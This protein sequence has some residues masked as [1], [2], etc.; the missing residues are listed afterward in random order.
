MNEEPRNP[1]LLEASF[2]TELRQSVLTLGVSSHAINK[3]PSWGLLSDMVSAFLSFWWVILLFK[4]G[5]RWN[6]KVLSHVPKHKRL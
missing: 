5:P 6:A 3:C 1:Q 4:R 2:L